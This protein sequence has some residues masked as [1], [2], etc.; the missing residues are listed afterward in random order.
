MTTAAETVI[1]ATQDWLVRAVIGLNL[2]PFARAVYAGDRIRYVVSDATTPEAL[3]EALAEELQALADIDET[4]TETTLLIHPQAM[5]D[6]IDFHFFTQ[7]ADRANERPA[8]PHA[9]DRKIAR[10][11]SGLRAPIGGLR[12]RH[13]AQ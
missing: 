8:K 6:F 2:C 9:A 7:E 3:L 12:N 5:T 4:R 13:L 10:G 11:A 1:A